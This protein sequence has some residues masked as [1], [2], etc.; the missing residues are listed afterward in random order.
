[1]M[2]M[3][4]YCTLVR[5]ALRWVQLQFAKTLRS[6]LHAFVV[7]LYSSTPRAVHPPARLVNKHTACFLIW[8]EILVHKKPWYIGKGLGLRIL[9]NAYLLTEWILSDFLGENVSFHLPLLRKDPCFM[10]WPQTQPTQIS[11][12]SLCKTP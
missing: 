4:V 5:W 6:R 10:H 7:T 11:C 1:M 8:I 12:P 2:N 9:L 3:N